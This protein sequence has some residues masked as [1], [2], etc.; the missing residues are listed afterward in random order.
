MQRKQSAA[1]TV[2]KFV[3]F[4]MVDFFIEVDKLIARM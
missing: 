1:A 4:S 3:L 2:E